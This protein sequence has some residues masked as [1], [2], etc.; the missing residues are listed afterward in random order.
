M[1]LSFQ[2]GRPTA[3]AIIPVGYYEATTGSVDTGRALV[4]GKYVPVV[5]RVAMNMTMLD[6]T[7]VNAELDDEV[8]LLGC[9]GDAQITADELADK[10]GTISYEVLSRIKPTT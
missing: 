9:Q 3:L 8:V 7:D 5:G 4:Q 1:G 2:A 6:V 10:M